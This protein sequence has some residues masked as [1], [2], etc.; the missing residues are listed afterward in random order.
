V[1]QH[2]C[3]AVLSRGGDTIEHRVHGHKGIVQLPVLAV[4]VD[5]HAS[6]ADFLDIFREGSGCL[7]VR[8]LV[9]MMNEWENI[10]RGS[11]QILIHECHGFIPK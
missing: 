1:G 7:Q 3:V 4:V 8:A 6:V 11:S 9:E 2:G 10:C 5:L